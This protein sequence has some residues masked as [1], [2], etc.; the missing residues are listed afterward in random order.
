M[1]KLYPYRTKAFIFRFPPIYLSKQIVDNN[2]KR[3][4]QMFYQSLGDQQNAERTFQNNEGNEVE[5]FMC[6]GLHQE[7]I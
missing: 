6:A 2:T 3:L 1:F 4:Q 5:S 7:L